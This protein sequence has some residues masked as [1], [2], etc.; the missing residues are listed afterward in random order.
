M[1]RVALGTRL[2]HPPPQVKR[3]SGRAEHP[4]SCDTGG[5][6]T[7]PPPQC[8]LPPVPAGG[9]LNRQQGEDPAPKPSHPPPHLPPPP[10]KPKPPRAA[11]LGTTAGHKPDLRGDKPR[12]GDKWGNP[13]G[14]QVSGGVLGTH[15]SLAG[16]ERGWPSPGTLLRSAL[17]CSST[18]LPALPRA[19]CQTDIY[20][21]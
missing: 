20:I 4:R 5:V 11:E 19:P 15:G 8:P 14:T 6:G 7:A 13:Q 16:P 17:L 18:P 10:P 1:T 3:D 21:L 2:R 12:P 9:S